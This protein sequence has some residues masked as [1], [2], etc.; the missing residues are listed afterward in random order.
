MISYVDAAGAMKAWIATRTSTL[1]GQG[2]PL[3]MGAHL[4]LLTGSASASYAYLTLLPGTYLPLG[5]ESPV[6]V[7]RIRAQ[8]YGIT[9]EA[10][11]NASMALADEICEGLQGKPQIV[12]VPATGE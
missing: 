11:T 8:V 9:V 10:T 3:Q 12:T 7:F 4:K 5:A 1:V 2:N 6:V